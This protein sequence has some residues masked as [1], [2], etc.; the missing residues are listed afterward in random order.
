MTQ[1]A[2]QLDLQVAH[3]IRFDFTF[4]SI[5]GQPGNNTVA[6]ANAALAAGVQI[7]TLPPGAVPINCNAYVDVAFNNGT[8]N[9]FSVGLTATGTDF[10]SSGS[11][12]SKAAVITAAPIAAIATC[13]A[14]TSNA[15]TPIYLSTSQTGTAPTTGQCTI[16]LSYHPNLG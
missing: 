2:R 10:V 14:V 1:S 8:N 3:T 5:Q 11:L 16:S 6:L 7:G 12:A 15:G 9:L 13:K 4:N